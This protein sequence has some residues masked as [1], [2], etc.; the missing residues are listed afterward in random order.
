MSNPS[1]WTYFC[2]APLRLGGFM[3]RKRF[4]TILKALAIT[5]RSPPAF[6]D[7]FWEVREI[8]EAWN[9]NMTEQFTP[10]WVSCLAE[11]M[12][13]WT[14]KYSCPGWMFMPRK[15]W[16]FGNEYHTVCCSL[17]GILW[18][19]ELVEGKDAPS[20]LVPK[21]NN[22]GKTVGLLLRVLEPIFGKGNMVVLDSGFCVLKGIVELKKRGVYASALIKKWK[23]WPKYIKGDAIKEHFD[24][25]DVGDCD[26][27]KGNMDKVPFHVYAMKEPDYVM[28]LMLTYG[29]NLRNGKENVGGW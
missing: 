26:S 29:T 20:Q 16:P 28:S 24:D 3:S 1:T 22:H 2:Y 10:S 9:A 4:D 27:W 18:Q 7:R 21:F 13:T 23:Y 6:R 17:S 19:M 11:S 5:S 8:L 25:K 14:N 15:P 12:S